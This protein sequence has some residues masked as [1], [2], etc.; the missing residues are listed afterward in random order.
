MLRFGH[1]FD[2]RHDAEI[3]PVDLLGLIQVSYGEA[4]VVNLPDMH[5]LPPA[6]IAFW[7][8]LFYDNRT[9]FS[10][11]VDVAVIFIVYIGHGL[12]YRLDRHVQIFFGVSVADIS[13]VVRV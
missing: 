2:S 10:L 13:V 9:P 11:F 7:E 6:S 3:L 1:V 5:G 4:Y 12:I 8:V